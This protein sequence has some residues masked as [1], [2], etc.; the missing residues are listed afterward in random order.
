[1]KLNSNTTLLIV[2]TILIAGGLYWYIFT[3]AP[4]EP[5]LTQVES[6]EN[7]L[8]NQFEL[9]VSEMG[10]ISFDTKIFSD[11]RFTSLNDLSVVITSEE[12][13]RADPFAPTGARTAP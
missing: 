4:P 2:S 11:P 1:M 6:T 9:L 10:S 8:Q 7:P 13:G 5:S 3:D 12:V